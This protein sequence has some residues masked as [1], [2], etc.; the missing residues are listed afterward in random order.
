MGLTFLKLTNGTDWQT[1]ASPV[2]YGRVFRG[3]RAYVHELER[4]P[5]ER[6]FTLRRDHPQLATWLDQKI[7]AQPY[8]ELARAAEA[9][10]PVRSSR[11]AAVVLHLF[12]HGG[13]PQQLSP[14]GCG[15]LTWPVVDPLNREVVGAF[16]VP[17][18]GIE[19]GGISCLFFADV[20]MRSASTTF[21]VDFLVGMKTGPSIRWMVV[22]V[23]GEEHDASRDK[24]KTR[25]LGLPTS[26][27]KAEDVLS[28]SF[29]E[30]LKGKLL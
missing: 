30:L 11:E 23:D 28:Q 17:A 4:E 29:I 20:A 16:K 24:I 3:R 26:R 18:V 10:V 15:F 27:F 19:L 13:I 7:A 1:P 12:A 8:A 25:S 22:E 5:A 6:F 21:V 2:D 14:Q 9:T